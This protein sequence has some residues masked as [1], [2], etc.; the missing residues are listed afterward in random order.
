MKREYDFSKGERGKLYRPGTTLNLPRPGEKPDW[1]GPDNRLCDF[2]ARE[3]GKTLN[4]YREQPSLVTE[5]ANQEHDTAHGGYA[6]RQLFELVQNSADALAD[7]PDGKGS[8]LVRL[9]QDTLYCADDGEAPDEEGVQALM[10]S[11][12]SPKRDTRKIGRFGLGFKSV[13]GV[14]DSPEFYSRPG[15]FRFDKRQAAERIAEAAGASRYPVLRL[16]IPVDAR[17]VSEDDDDLRELMTWATNIVRL[18]LKPGAREDLAKQIEDFPPEFLLFVGHVRYLSLE[19]ADKSRD[20]GI[21]TLN[22]EIRLEAD[23]GY[24]RWKCF[25]TK[26]KLSAAALEDRRSLDDSGEVPIWWAAPLDRLHEPGH[27]WT[28]FPT[29]TSSLLAG[30]LNAPWK[31]NE[32]RQNLL[33]GPYNDELIDTAAKLVATHL[34]ELNTESD[35]ARHLDALPRRREAGDTR[36]I[37]RLRERLDEA[38]RGI[39]VVPDQ[40]GRLREPEKIAYAPRKVTEPRAEEA[41]QKW[42]AFDLRPTDWLHHRALTRERLAR[43]DRLYPAH[44]APRASLW[45]WL[46]ALVEGRHGEDAIAASKA[47][48]RVAAAI[49]E[50]TG[51]EKYLADIVLTQ[52]GRWRRPD[53]DNVFLPSPDDELDEAHLVHAALAADP[54]TAAALKALGI[55]HASAESHFRSL[56]RMLVP[57]YTREPDGA[58]WS[59]FW[60]AS[61]NVEADEAHAIIKDAIGRKDAHHGYRYWSICARA[62]SGDWK[63]LHSILLPGDIVSS[64]SDQ[65]EGVTVDTEF[66]RKD[67]TLLDRLGATAAPREDQQ[68]ARAPTNAACN[69]GISKAGS[70]TCLP[71]HPEGA[72]QNRGHGRRRR[73]G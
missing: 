49:P 4:A 18:P 25:E 44:Q 42:G 12:M 19:H 28:F 73:F 63:P 60:R 1:L 51:R 59:E 57:G 50:E 21:Q 56:V 48:I 31:T 14:T 37:E 43:I 33:T 39:P 13:L 26:H 65:D 47:A 23:D 69:G 52:N 17:E 2:I 16:P 30:I 35:P 68:L 61:R 10:F 71:A 6:H 29:H 38:L 11:Y 45:Q 72:L 32:D 7:A 36:H 46:E 64:N 8:I 24:S 55:K 22:G 27:F 5:H 20:F 62:R 40:S 66:H 67:L 58:R 15:S 70:A 9:T 41:L 53:A 34:S 3:T 54:E